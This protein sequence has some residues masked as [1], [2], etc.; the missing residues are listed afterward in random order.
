MIEPYK[1]HVTV[2]EAAVEGKR[3]RDRWSKSR[4]RERDGKVLLR[5]KQ[6]LTDGQM[7]K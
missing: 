5:A 3:E 6:E 4:E 1:L 7:Q 2:T